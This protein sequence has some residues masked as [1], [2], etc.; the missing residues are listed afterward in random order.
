MIVTPKAPNLAHI[1]LWAKAKV[2][3]GGRVPNFKDEGQGR[4]SNFAANITEWTW[5][6]V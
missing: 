6:V 4:R 3:F 1:I 2:F 5:T